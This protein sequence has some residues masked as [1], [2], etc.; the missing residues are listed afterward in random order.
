M[1]LLR[2]VVVAGI[3]FVLAPP[4]PAGAATRT[5]TIT[6]RSYSPERVSIVIEDTVRWVNETNQRHSVSA[7]SDSIS[8]GESFDSNPNCDTGF[9]FN[10]CLRPGQSFSHTFTT[11]GTFTYYC[12]I[13]GTDAPF[14]DCGMCGRV[15]VV[16]RSSPTIAP[17]TPGGTPSGSPSSTASVSTSPSP[18][19]GDSTSVTGSGLAAPG[20]DDGGNTSVLA[21]AALGVVLLAASGYAVYRSMIRR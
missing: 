19:P 18:S 14:P 9:L 17:T 21:V 1:R 3:V 8:K 7:S 15:T 2:L 20:S 12:R 13:H 5:V 16:R 11:R 6:G 4:V 10:R